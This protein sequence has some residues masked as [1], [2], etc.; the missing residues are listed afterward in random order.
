[1]VNVVANGKRRLEVHPVIRNTTMKLCYSCNHLTQRSPSYCPRCGRSYNMRI[2]PAGH[3]NTRD[4]LACATCGSI[5]LSTPQRQRPGFSAILIICKFSVGAR[6]LALTML[7][8][9]DFAIALT[10]SPNDLLGRMVVGGILA[11]LWL[12]YTTVA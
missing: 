1:M 2:C 7:F 3:K 10:T 5:E 11:C 9:L 8:A 6:L 12:L 4:T